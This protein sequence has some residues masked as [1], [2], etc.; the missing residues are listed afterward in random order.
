MCRKNNRK[1]GAFYEQIAAEYLS[2]LG[3]EILDKNFRNR[4]GEIDIVAKDNDYIVIC[5]VKF[6]G[7]SAKGDPLEAI[8][9]RKQRKLSFMAAYYLS[10]KGY[11]NDVP[12]RFD[13]V[14]IDGQKQV[15][16]IKNAFDYCL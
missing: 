11:G 12:V 3:Y 5:E 13:V 4:N 9:F 7:D 14:A 8:D 1:V 15:V 2:S 10:V 6:R 16:H